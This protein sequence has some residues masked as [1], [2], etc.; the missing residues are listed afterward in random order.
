M[1]NMLL[2]RA[3]PFDA[4]RWSWLHLDAAGVARGVIHTGTLADAA[5]EANGLRVIVLL[6]GS[7]CLLT[8]VHI[9]GRRRKRL[10]QAVPYALEEQL[11]DDVEKLHFALGAELVSGTWQVAVTNKQRLHTLMGSLTE[12]GLDVQQVLPEQLALPFSAGAISVLIDHDMA[13]VRNSEHSGYAVDAENL[14]AVLTSNS[15]DDAAV[16]AVINLYLEQDAVLPDNGNYPGHLHLE[17]YARD[18]LG[19]LAQGLDIKAINLLQGEFSHAGEWNR[20]LYPWRAT[21]ALLLAGILISN[22]VKAVDYYRLSQQ[23]DQLKMQIEETFRK[24]LPETRRLVNPRA[25]MQQKLDELQQGSSSESRFL[26][27]LGQAGVVIK[28][29]EGVEISGANYRGG[30]LDLDLNVD[31]L[32]LLDRLKQAL[33][34]NGTLSVDIQSATTGSDQRI[35]SRLRITGVE[36]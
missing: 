4:R 24:A 26:N 15:P 9:P 1:R 11:S 5:A 7:D 3:N 10:L 23:S 34:K 19:V 36:T 20:V 35:K 12:S 17:H 33:T 2:L 27:L 29:V 18:P 28:D 21:A 14:D 13:V 31:S 30:R 22:A 25:Q 16:T 6:P 32:Q 8:S